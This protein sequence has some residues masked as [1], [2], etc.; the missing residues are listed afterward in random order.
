MQQDNKNNNYKNAVF[1]TI[2][3]CIIFVALQMFLG[4]GASSNKKVVKYSDFITHLQDNKVVEAM[5]DDDG[6]TYL[7]SSGHRY[8]THNP[9]HPGDIYLIERLIK[10]NV[11]FA[12]VDASEGRFTRALIS[13]LPLLIIIMIEWFVIFKA[14]GMSGR[15]GNFGRSKAKMLDGTQNNIT[16]KDVAGV[17][18]AKH[19]VEEIVHFLRDPARFS[20]LGARIPK[21]V[22]LVGSPGT[23]KTLLAKAIAGE[24]DVA[25][26]SISGSDFVEM[27]VG[28]GASRVRSMF[29]QAKKHAPCIIFI[30]EIDAVGRSRSGQAFVNDEREQTLNQMLVEMDGFEANS[31]II[32]IAATNRPD[33]LDNAL[34]RPGRFDRQVYVPLPDIKGREE[35][36]RVH[37][38]KVPL[39][40]DADLSILARGTP[41][42]SGA[43]LANV[44]NEAAL[45]AARR[46]KTH[47]SMRDLDDARDKV[48]LGTEQKSR[49]MKEEDRK[50]TAYHE[51]GHALVSLHYPK[52]A[53]NMHKITIVPHGMALGFVSRLQDDSSHMT[54]KEFEIEIA[55]CSGGRVAEEIIFGSENITSGASSDIKQASRIARRMVKNF[56]MGEDIGFIEYDDNEPVSPATYK[57]LE[58]EVKKIINEGYQTAKEIIADQQEKLHLLAQALLEYETLTKDEAISILNGDKIFKSSISEIKEHSA[59]ARMPFTKNNDDDKTAE[60]VNA[61]AADASAEAAETLTKAEASATNSKEDTVS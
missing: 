42:F 41:G 35:I 57:T 52:S 48:M 11:A 36:L 14:N 21:G 3:T 46:N 10:N 51:A 19:E 26:F 28:V 15:I 44:I 49:V 5:I 45:L 32:I 39:S 56:G 22:L 17:E 2:A 33:V 37:S 50:I 55:I 38:A 31:G 47:V 6:V 60:D 59:K 34:L 61:E 23:G 4:A 9:G 16:F 18:E 24:A 12:G 20:K 25:F 58:D 29:E 8:L 40:S 13:W 7:D 43:E 53:N 27:F 1:W 30:D 54:K